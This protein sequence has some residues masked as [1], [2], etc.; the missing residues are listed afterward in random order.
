MILSKF[1]PLLEKHMMESMT[2]K[3]LAATFSKSGEDFW[4]EITDDSQRIHISL[5]G[6]SKESVDVSVNSETRSIHVVS[7][8][9]KAVNKIVARNKSYEFKVP[10]VANLETVTC[11]MTCGVLVIDIKN[12]EPKKAKV[13]QIEVK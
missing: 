1:N 11:E 13:T 4:T 7:Y 5:P 2:F 3:Q 8:P 9:E 10:A 6:H 12:S